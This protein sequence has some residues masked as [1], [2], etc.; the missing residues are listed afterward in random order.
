MCTQFKF[1][2]HIDTHHKHRR[3]YASMYPSGMYMEGI[4]LTSQY[5]LPQSVLLVDIYKIANMYYV[6][7]I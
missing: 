6:H 3:L 2:V 1:A 7:P 5:Y 4:V